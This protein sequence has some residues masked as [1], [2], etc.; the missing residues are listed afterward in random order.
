MSR[1][2][3]FDVIGSF[4]KLRA[5]RV[6]TK[7]YEVGERKSKIVTWNLKAEEIFYTGFAKFRNFMKGWSNHN[8]GGGPK[9]AFSPS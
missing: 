2:E 5:P 1:L 3:F 9:F 8:F 6:N 7:K 4:V